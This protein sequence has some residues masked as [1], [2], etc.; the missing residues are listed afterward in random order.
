VYGFFFAEIFEL[1]TD[2]ADER[3]NAVAPDMVRALA[4]G[5]AAGYAEPGAGEPPWFDQIRNLAG[6]L[7]FALRQKDYKKNPEAYPGSIADAAGVIRVLITG[8]RQSPDL[9]QTCAALGREE[10]LRRV[11]ALS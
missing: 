4:S 5:F 8:A 6:D 2:P 10:V 11:T 9:E 3:F 7:G 1:V